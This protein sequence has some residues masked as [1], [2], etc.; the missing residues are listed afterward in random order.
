MCQSAWS[1]Y[2]FSFMAERET[3]IDM[4]ERSYSSWFSDLDPGAA[5]STEWRSDRAQSSL[6]RYLIDDSKAPRSVIIKRNLL[7]ESPP[8]RPR[9]GLRSGFE[10]KHLLEADALE[11]AC[12]AIG[13][14]DQAPGLGTVRLFERLDDGLVIEA[15]NASNLGQRM[16][17]R[18][19]FGV[20]RAVCL[21]GQW[22]RRFHG[23]ALDTPEVR[24]DGPSI[25]AAFTDFQEFLESELGS[26]G[27]TSRLSDVADRLASEVE[28]NPPKLGLGH[29]DFAPRNVLVSHDG[30]VTII[31]PLGCQRCPIE[32][33]LA[34]FALSLRRGALVPWLPVLSPRQADHL[35]NALLLGYRAPGRA[36]TADGESDQP[37]LGFT[38]LDR[39]RYEAFGV[40]VTLDAMAADHVRGSHHESLP[41]R[42]LRRGL[43][44]TRDL[45]VDRLARTECAAQN[46]P[47]RLER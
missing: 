18:H 13:P 15:I 39:F 20:D 28:R 38:G 32:E 3:T 14:A 19:G 21:A 25:A 26:M 41:R 31:D 8:D 43:P 35:E 27:L 10:N 2:I 47:R 42:V 11:A 33:D 44:S 12:R 40:L 9:L 36:D 30:T 7:H 4:I 6:T 34:Y 46:I 1:Q 24:G 45:L 22:L 37:G 17:Q 23:A 5:I 29:G 16:K